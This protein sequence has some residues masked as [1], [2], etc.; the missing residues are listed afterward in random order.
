M[1][2]LLASGTDEEGESPA[3]NSVVKG[4]ANGVEGSKLDPPPPPRTRKLQT[5]TITKTTLLNPV[6]RRTR[7]SA[8]SKEDS[9]SPFSSPSRTPSSR[10]YS[11]RE[12]DTSP[13]K[14]GKGLDYND[15]SKEKPPPGP[16]PARKIRKEGVFNNGDDAGTLDGGK[17][18][19]KTDD[20]DLLSYQNLKN[21]KEVKT[22]GQ[23]DETVNDTSEGS[24][25][26]R[27]DVAGGVERSENSIEDRIRQRAN[28]LTGA[29]RHENS[30]G[31]GV[32]DKAKEATRKGSDKLDDDDP[33]HRP[34]SGSSS[35]DVK[36]SGSFNLRRQ[37]SGDKALG[38]FYHNRRSQMADHDNSDESDKS[39]LERSGSFSNPQSPVAAR[40]AKAVRDSGDF[41]QGAGNIPMSPLL[42]SSSSSDFLGE[43]P[44]YTRKAEKTE[45]AGSSAGAAIPLSPRITVSEEDHEVSGFCA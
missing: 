4:R 22:R 14:S 45:T 36:R 30:A 5:E 27:T 15:I 23:T 9:V 8:S 39:S 11:S 33:S 40:A 12:E 7:D 37:M 38:I 6:S 24:T 44:R 13:P 31:T 25:R 19:N 32:D 3:K 1:S 41:N 2:E 35:K 43:L 34:K 29:K 16:S 10:S 17:S 18:R 26:S 28:A 21:R 42:S 20:E